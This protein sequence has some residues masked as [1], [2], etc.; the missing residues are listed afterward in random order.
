MAH[1]RQQ[2][3]ERTLKPQII[4]PVCA[5]EIY[6]SG[7]YLPE[8]IVHS[9]DLLEQ[10]NS[11]A[12]YGIPTDT[13]SKNIGIA[14]RRV[15]SDNELPSTLAI[16]AANQALETASIS[17]VDKI[18]FCGISKD[19][20]EPATAHTIN[21][22]MNLKA[23]DAYDVTDACFGFIRGLQDCIRSIKLGE[24]E[25]ALVLTGE[26]PSKGIF[27]F[28]EQLKAGVDSAV[29]KKLIGFLTAGDSGGAILLTRSDNYSRGFGDF[30]TL[31]NSDLW[32]KC[33]YRI[34]RHG[35]YQGQMLMGYLTA[36]GRKLG[37]A[38]AERVKSDQGW[39][40]PDHMLSH[41]TGNGSFEGLIN[42]GLASKEK[43]FKTY[44]KLGNLMSA[45][46]P[47]NYHLQKQSGVF[48]TGERVGGIFNGSG[49][50]FGYFTYLN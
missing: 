16:K 17:N 50:I 27:N 9:D 43:W 35:Q 26:N 6:S 42:L 21:Q 10:A 45:T 12:N 24:I 20:A 14:E 23:K 3:L 49:L 37:E 1:F 11:Y 4:Q 19:Q 31:S 18:V 22:K 34:N 25:T 33:N 7:M 41:N 47:V 28:I 5:V 15:A 29:A 30:H 8:K 39:V 38:L 46:F 36:H 13:M 40:E 44:D 2:Q 48:K 32:D